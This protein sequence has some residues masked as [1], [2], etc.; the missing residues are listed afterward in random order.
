MTAVLLSGAVSGIGLLMLASVLVQQ[1][2]SGPVA[3]AQ[4]DTRRARG[5]R[6]ASLTTDRRHE[7]ESPRMRKLGSDLN[8][9]L[10]RN[11]WTLPAGLRATLSL[12]GVS[13]E[14]FL[15]RTLGAAVLGFFVPSMVLGPLAAMGLVGLVTPLWL[16]FFGALIGAL[17][18]YLQVRRQAEDRRRAF[19]H[20]VSSFLDLVA[21]N[22]AGGR[23]VPEALQAASNI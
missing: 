3:L 23:G 12:V 17:V 19:R 16:G 6:Q 4:L 20:V 5:R 15:A 9:V 21:M 13:T 7:S 1:E 8:D 10:V 14:I 2:T 18:P 11:D 22:L